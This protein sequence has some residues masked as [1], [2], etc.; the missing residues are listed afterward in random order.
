MILQRE[1]YA[2]D[3][4]IVAKEL[5]GKILVH[6]TSEGI[7]AGRIVETEAYKGPEDKAAHSYGNRRT[8]R[9]ETMY[10]PK[11]HSYIY[12]IYGLYHCL[13]VTSGSILGKPE[14]TLIRALEPVQG[15]ELMMKRRGE[16]GKITNVA[17]GPGRLC[18]AMGLSKIH[19]AQY[20]VKPPLY[21]DEGQSVNPADIVEASR[22][23][24][25]YAGDCKDLPWRFYIKN[26]PY[27]SVK[28]KQKL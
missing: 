15:I 3:S 2:R 8:P 5:L 23:G 10:G 1:F 17:S 9:T 20:M 22:I 6:E 13:N 28:L 19:N 16:T 18:V 21:I 4:L 27:V 25:D 7:G 24:V 26:N 14:A 11:G 12:L